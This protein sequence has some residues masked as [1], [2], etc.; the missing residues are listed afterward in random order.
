MKAIGTLGVAIATASVFGLVLI[1]IVARWLTQD[2]YA[3]FLVI[4]GVVFAGGSV[5]SVIEQETARQVTISESRKQPVPASIGQLTLVALLASTI[6]LAVLT[7][8]P[9]GQ[10][11]FGRSL[12]LV[13]LTF[14]AFSGFAAQFAVRGIFLGRQDHIRYA[15]LV[16]SEATLRIIAIGI[17]WILN[18]TPSI[19]AAI[20]AVVVGCFGWAPMARRAF[21]NIDLKNGKEP[22]GKATKRVLVLASSNALLA[23]VMTGFPT[24]VGSVIGTSVGLASFFSV[25]TISRI[26]LTLLSPVQALVVP[27]TTRALL[28][29]NHEY[30]RSMQIQ[31]L[32]VLLLAAGFLA[33]GGWLLGPWAVRLAFGPDYVVS[34]ALVSLMLAVTV[35]M[36]GAQLQTAVFVSL[37]RYNLIAATWG[38][39]FLGAIMAISFT[40][41]DSVRRGTA[42]FIA[43]ALLPYLASTIALRMALT[44]K[45]SGESSTTAG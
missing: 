2:E 9:F 32:A 19:P 30:I 6:T 24:L 31:L 13:A 20:A 1:G 39:A 3:A 38:S 12:W 35:F 22:W 26:P 34:S 17:L 15:F 14:I 7:L 11:V 10:T 27:T 44:T 8:L 36:A 5:L 29:N 23:S 45:T 37:E 42:G 40:T 25:V 33:G 4:W 16:I 41:G 43:A 18:V 21:S 28:D